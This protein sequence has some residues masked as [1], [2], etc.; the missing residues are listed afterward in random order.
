MDRETENNHT[1]CDW[2]CETYVSVK[3]TVPWQGKPSLSLLP[4]VKFFRLF[5]LSFASTTFSTFPPKLPPLVLGPNSPLKAP[6]LKPP[7]PGSR[8]RQRPKRDNKSMGNACEPPKKKLAARCASL[9]SSAA[10]TRSRSWRGA[11]CFGSSQSERLI[12]GKSPSS[13]LEMRG[14][15]LVSL[16]KQPK[17]A[18]GFP[19]VDRSGRSQDFGRPSS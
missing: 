17:K 2:M 7:K 9:R 5:W 12:W 1:L 14:L 10:K 6:P 16:F 18:T 3:Q 11:C 19:T 15:Q 8:K 13:W 4:F